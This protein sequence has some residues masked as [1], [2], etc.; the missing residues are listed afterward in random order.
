MAASHKSLHDGAT[1]QQS[2][3]EAPS[4]EE[5]VLEMHDVD[6]D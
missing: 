1:V 2:K 4:I 3:G 6:Y 5:C